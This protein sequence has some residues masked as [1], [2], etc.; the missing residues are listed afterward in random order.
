MSFQ[1][2]LKDNVAIDCKPGNAFFLL[3]WLVFYIT[4]TEYN[5]ISH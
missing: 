1:H 3:Q 2:I 4:P 5:K